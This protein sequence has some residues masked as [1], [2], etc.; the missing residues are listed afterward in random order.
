VNQSISKNFSSS[1]IILSSLQTSNPIGSP[2]SLNEYVPVTPSWI[3][4]FG[5]YVITVNVRTTPVCFLIRSKETA[6]SYRKYFDIL[7]KQS[8]K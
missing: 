5:D 1:L 7:W 3:D 8:V 2:F 6:D 4:M